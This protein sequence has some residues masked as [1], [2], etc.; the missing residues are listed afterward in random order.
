MPRSEPTEAEQSNAAWYL[1]SI[2]TSS[3]AETDHE[4]PEGEERARRREASPRVLFRSDPATKEA[5]VRGDDEDKNGEDKDRV[6]EDTKKIPRRVRM[7]RSEPTEAEQSNA[8]WYLPSIVTSSVA[9]TD[10]EKPE[11]EARLGRRE[12]SPWEL[13]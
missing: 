13:L 12:A 10:H 2:V 8:A 4:K 5:A 1:P 9:E 6:Q 11:G 7:P 3:V